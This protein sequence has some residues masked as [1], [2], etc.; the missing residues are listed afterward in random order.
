[1]PPVYLSLGSTVF[2]RYNFEI[3]INS[4]GESNDQALVC[5]TTATWCCE[6]FDETS[7]GS[8]CINKGFGEWLDPNGR[9]VIQSEDVPTG[10]SSLFYKSR[11]PQLIRL[12]RRGSTSSQTGSYCCKIPQVSSSGRTV[13]HRTLCANLGELSP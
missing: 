5:H 3:N 6:E 9:V 13:V 12:H 4:I 7:P 2:F 8:T 11:G 1:M 10:T